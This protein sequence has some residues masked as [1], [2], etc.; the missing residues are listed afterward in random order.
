[1][2]TSV[3]KEHHDL[4]KGLSF[5]KIGIKGRKLLGKRV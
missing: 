3:E 5:V 4:E 1:V 2:Q